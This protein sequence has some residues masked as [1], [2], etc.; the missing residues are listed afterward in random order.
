MIC[1]VE[2]LALYN[3]AGLFRGVYTGQRKVGTVQI[4]TKS[5]ASFDMYY[6]DHS[7]EPVFIETNHK[8]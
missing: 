7:S 2:N 1:F 5:L 3:I 8:S 4:E 6:V